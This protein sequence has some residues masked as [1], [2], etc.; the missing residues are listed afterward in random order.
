MVELACL[1]LVRTLLALYTRAVRRLLIVH[2]LLWAITK[3]GRQR[4]VIAR[5]TELCQLL[6]LKKWTKQHFG[7]CRHERLCGGGST[8]WFWR[9]P[10]MPHA[11][12]AEVP[13]SAAAP[14]VC[15]VL[16]VRK[17]TRLLQPSLSRMPRSRDCASQRHVQISRGTARPKASATTRFYS[18]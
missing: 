1:E 16:P 14:S 4:L 18:A 7:F 11:R 9:L 3:L 6:S 15:H 2:A 17:R 12:A 8:P 5:S 13:R 10:R